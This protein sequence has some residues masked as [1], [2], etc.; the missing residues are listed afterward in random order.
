MFS[1]NELLQSIGNN[2]K[3]ED[4]SE[5]INN[6][7]KKLDQ[8]VLDLFI[9]LSKDKGFEELDKLYLLGHPKEGIEL[10][11]DEVQQFL[12]DLPKYEISFFKAY[13]VARQQ[14]EEKEKLLAIEKSKCEIE[15]EEKI[16]NKRLGELK[17]KKRT[18]SSVH[19]I[20]ADSIRR[21]ILTN[22]KYKYLISLENELLS[23]KDR[24]YLFKK[25]VKVL[26]LRRIDLS[27]ILK[28]EVSMY[29]QGQP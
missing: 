20:T 5:I 11:V 13:Q 14:G 1:K 26:E 18:L 24:K 2:L 7:T 10:S 28:V 8:A 25:I 15:V 22:D 6:A 19:P 9:S 16:S 3:K 23:L 27:A 29:A 17:D 4:R 21:E 12:F